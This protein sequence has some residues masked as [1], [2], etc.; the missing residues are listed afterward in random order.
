MINTRSTIGLILIVLGLIIFLGNMNIINGDFTLFIIGGGFFVAYYLSGKKT[1]QRKIGFLIAALI[2]LMVGFFDIAD[3]YV[4]SELSGTLFF[5]FFG[6]VFLLIYILHTMHIKKGEG[7]WPL[8]ISIGL[9]AFSLFIYLVEVV[10]LRIVENIVE[11]Y[12]PIIFIIIGVIVLFKGISE[13]QKSK[14]DQ[15][16]D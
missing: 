7:K 3:N 12:W 6:T 4:R 10:D 5:M 13:K 11:K 14:N 8:Y 9:Y 15:G 2:I 1:L 16:K